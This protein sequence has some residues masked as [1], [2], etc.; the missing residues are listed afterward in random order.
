MSNALE[1]VR[2]SS[3]FMTPSDQLLGLRLAGRYE[4]E[5][6]LARGGMGA[7][8]LGT[9][10]ETRNAVAIKVV[11]PDLEA[12]AALVA[13]F[14]RETRQLAAMQHPNVVKLLDHG[15]EN[16]RRFIVME[17]V[18]GSNLA[19]R[20]IDDG[21]LTLEAFVPIAR[22][23][24]AAVGYAHVHGIM[25]RDI[26]PDN[27]MI[28]AHGE[29]KLLDFGLARLEGDSDRVTTQ[30]LVGTAAYLAPEHILGQTVDVRVDVYALGVLFYR[31][32][33]GRFPLEADNPAALIYKHVNGKPVPLPMV[34]PEGRA[35]P[36]ELVRLIHDCLAKS[37]DDRPANADE[38]LERLIDSVPTAL[39]GLS[40]SGSWTRGVR[41]Q[42]E[43]TIEAPSVEEEQSPTLFRAEVVRVPVERSPGRWRLGV[44]ALSAAL[45]GAGAALAYKLLVRDATPSGLGL[46]DSSPA[47][48]VERTTERALER[49]GERTVRDEAA[50]HDEPPT[51]ERVGLAPTVVHGPVDLRTV[52]PAAVRV[53]GRFIGVTP[54]SGTLPAGRRWVELH[55]PGFEAWSAELW[56]TPDQT[57]RLTLE[58]QP[59][60]PEELS[61]VDDAKRSSGSAHDE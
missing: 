31:L 55:A 46:V 2:G 51:R 6:Y 48:V 19:R 35:L 24:L 59:V 37:P 47:D 41:E 27:V 40:R 3:P 30:H 14:E 45:L 43:A 22:G 56:V 23:I 28:D 26:K 25:I 1:S 29:V 38:V 11:V 53:D 33:S 57:A 7:V 61:R 36:P 20:L 42:A 16:G 13:R 32:L 44:V 60:M 15:I 34:L 50:T 12:D 21:P 8:F 39:F 49:A 58:L 54:W 18:R 4:V 10:R 5:R 17:Y 52:P 9:D